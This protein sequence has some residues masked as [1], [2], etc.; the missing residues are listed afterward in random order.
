MMWA[1]TGD[2]HRGDTNRR[3]P[4]LEGGGSKGS[5]LGVLCLFTS[6]L[7]REPGTQEASR[8]P[9]RAQKPGGQTA[10]WSG[11]CGYTMTRAG[12]ASALNLS[13]P[14][15]KMGCPETNIQHLACVWHLV[16]SQ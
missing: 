10:W 7:R 9:G 1:M 13:L 14:D 12:D 11:S 5:V 6:E 3:S 16:S 8:A 15:C 2:K 4:L